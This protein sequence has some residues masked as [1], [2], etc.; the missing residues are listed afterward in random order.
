MTIKAFAEK[1]D[2]PYSLAY[3]ASYD[4]RPTLRREGN[5]DFDEQEMKI[6]LRMTIGRKVAKNSDQ[7][8]KLIKR[9]A[10]LYNIAHRL[11][12]VEPSVTVF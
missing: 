9:N 3:E 7:V 1:Y 5:K 2:I 6:A 10:E 12:D 11:G 8:I 4:V